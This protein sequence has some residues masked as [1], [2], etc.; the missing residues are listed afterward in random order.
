GSVPDPAV[1]NGWNMTPAGAQKWYGLARGTTLCGALGLA[2]PER[3]FVVST[4]QVALELQDPTLAQPNFKNATGNGA[5]GWIS[6]SYEQLSNA[7]DQGSMLQPQFA[8]I[9]T[10]NPDLTAFKER[11]GKLLH[12]HGLDDEVIPAQ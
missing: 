2:C 7:F 3:P 12:Y 11:G 6:L 10:D 4:D 9:N 1:D 8:H 5:D